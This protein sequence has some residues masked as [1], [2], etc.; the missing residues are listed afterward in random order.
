MP[1]LIMVD[2]WRVM[3]AMSLVLTCGR[4]G[5]KRLVF[6]PPFCSTIELT[7]RFF[8]LS[9]AWAAPL[10]AAR[11]TLSTFLPSGPLAVYAK[12]AITLSL[13]GSAIVYPA[14]GTL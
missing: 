9:S 10:S 5:P 8:F 6:F 13:L 4:G 1:A 14:G 12:T 3:T 11:M 7:V 2:S